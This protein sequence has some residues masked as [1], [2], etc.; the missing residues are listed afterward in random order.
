MHKDDASRVERYL[1]GDASAFEEVD[2][3]IHAVLQR[4]Y[5]RLRDEHEDLRQTVHAKVL[6]NLRSGRFLERSPLRAYVTSITHH[7][8]IDRLRKLYQERALARDWPGRPRESRANPYRAAEAMDEGKLLHQALLSLSSG[9][10]ELWRL[11]FVEK[12]SYEGVAERLAIPAGTVKSRM[13]HCRRKLLELL[14]RLRRPRRR[15][16][17]S[18]DR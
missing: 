4:V 1:E 14:G 2:G 13:W 6:D 11:V 9:C 7:T 17:L 12:L 18:L 10:R 8:T 3:W 16:G 15:R 5:P